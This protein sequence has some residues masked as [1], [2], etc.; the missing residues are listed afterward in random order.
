MTQTYDL[1]IIGGG[2]AG[3]MT[4]ITAS[5]NGATVALIEKKPKLGRKLLMTGKGRCN[6]TNA[7]FDSVSELVK[8]YGKNGRFLY[9]AFNQFSPQ[10]VVNFFEKNGAAT[11]VERGNRVFPTADSAQ[12]VLSTLENIAHKNGVEI[13]KANPVKR[14]THHS[15]HIEKI[16]LE[17]GVEIIAKNYVLATGGMSYPSTGSEGDGY[18]FAKDLGHT[19]TEPK[20]ALT[21]IIIEE[22]WVKELQGLSLKNVQATLW[23]SGKKQDER[24]GEALFTHEGMSGPIIIDMSKKIGELLNPC[25]S[26]QS[27]ES[28]H[29]KKDPSDK[30]QDDNNLCH[31]DRS[32]GIPQKNQKNSPLE[33]C[34]TGRGVTLQLDFKPALNFPTLDKRLQK[35]F[36]QNNTKMFKNSLNELLPSKL[37]PVIIDLS[38]ID[39]E[40][41]CCEIKKEERKKLLKLLKEFTL[42]IKKLDGFKKAIVTSGGINIKEIDPKTMKSKIVDNLYFAGEVIDIDGPTGGFNLQICWSTGKLA[43]QSVFDA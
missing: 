40:K 42:T 41:K 25:H 27:E 14:V 32:G 24:F 5:K 8:M 43:G 19:I 7:G 13:I 17:N 6:I 38:E 21:P 33:G 39:P 37:I 11:R 10:D 35:D 3:L 12:F 2:P 18:K 28:A 15:H 9:N 34:P 26:E 16:I 20:P 29:Q 22:K 23:Q 1:A 31:C 4:A 36:E 30:P